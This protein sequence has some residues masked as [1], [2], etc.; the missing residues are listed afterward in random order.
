MNSYVNSK[1]HNIPHIL[2][3]SIAHFHPPRLSAYYLIIEVWKTGLP[4]RSA[5]LKPHAGELVVGWVT[6]SESSL[7]LMLSEDAPISIIDPD[8]VNKRAPEATW[9]RSTTRK[10]IPELVAPKRTPADT[11]K[12]LL[13]G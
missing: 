13:E 1:F 5:V 3:L 11:L 7:L 2:T 10:E 9:T 12:A 6:T 4:V 8:E